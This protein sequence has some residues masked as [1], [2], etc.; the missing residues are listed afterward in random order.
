MNGSYSQRR[1]LKPK[2]AVIVVIDPR[3][4]STRE[5]VLLERSARTLEPKPERVEGRKIPSDE[6]LA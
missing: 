5:L 3:I 2:E 1:A 4:L 6:I